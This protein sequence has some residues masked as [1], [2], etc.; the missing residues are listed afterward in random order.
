MIHAS[1]CTGIG[2]CELAATWMGWENAFSCEIDEF[3]NKVLKYHYPN[4]VHYGNIFEQDFRQWR[5]RIDVLTAGFPCQ[6]FSVAGARNGAEDD[7]YL[8]NEVF[9]V[10]NEVRPTWFIGENVGGIT[11][12]VLP[13]EEVK[14]GSYEDIC[15]DS[16]TMYEKRQRYVIEQIRIDLESI[17]YQVQPIIIPACAVGAPHRRD[18]VWFI[19][20]RADTGVE[21]LQ[22]EGEDCIYAIRYATHATE[23]GLQERL[24]DGKQEDT[25]EIGA[26]LDDRLERHGGKRAAPYPDGKRLQGCGTTGISYQERKESRNEQSSELLFTGWENFPTQ[27]PICG[28]DARLPF[29]VHD[30]TISYGQWREKSIKAYGNTMCVPVSYEIFKAIE[31]VEEAFK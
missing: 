14:V 30:L 26:G 4:T 20:N 13:G 11:T 12:M 28:R 23:A 16:Y 17:G 9:R 3:C 21:G 7:R 25:E 29:N 24:D 5:G 6:P 15:G 2:A 8:W 31:Q 10:I 19:A 22:R 18:R 27:S 1:L